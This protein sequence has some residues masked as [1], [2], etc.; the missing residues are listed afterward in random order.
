MIT[1]PADGVDSLGARP[2]AATVM[3]NGGP[4]YIQK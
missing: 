2:S 1:A 4:M 3:T